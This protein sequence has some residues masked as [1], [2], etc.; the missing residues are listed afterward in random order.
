[1]VGR[2]KHQQESL[3]LEGLQLYYNKHTQ[4]LNL[5]LGLQIEPA[6]SIVSTYEWYDGK[7][8]CE[9]QSIQWD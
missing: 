7:D 8:A 3:D 9:G 4:K 5:R 6:T 1:M 2:L